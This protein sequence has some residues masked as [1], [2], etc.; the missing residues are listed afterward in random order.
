M[1]KKE[2]KTYKSEQNALFK[3]TLVRISKLK[4][5]SVDSLLLSENFRGVIK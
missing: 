1:N 4:N 5:S 3:Q 2:V